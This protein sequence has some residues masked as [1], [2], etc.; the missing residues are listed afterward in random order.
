M[1]QI[2]KEIT[3]PQGTFIYVRFLV[4]IGNLSYLKMSCSRRG[5]CNSM[6]KDNNICNFLS[7]EK[8][9]NTARLRKRLVFGSRE[10]IPIVNEEGNNLSASIRSFAGD[11]RKDI[12]SCFCTNQNFQM[13]K[14]RLC[15]I[16]SMSIIFTVAEKSSSRIFILLITTMTGRDISLHSNSLQVI[17]VRSRLTQKGDS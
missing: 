11:T 10:L 1:N 16:H 12:T 3:R 2:K 5:L 7:D 14:K 9:S 6:Q 8:I 15:L 13:K 17:T 4:R